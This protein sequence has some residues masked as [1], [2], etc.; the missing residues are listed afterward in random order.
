MCSDSCW[1]NFIYW[2]ADAIF[3]VSCLL[4][5]ELHLLIL[6]GRGHNRWG[7]HYHVWKHTHISLFI[8]VSDNKLISGHKNSNWVNCPTNDGGALPY[9]I[10]AGC[11]MREGVG[12]TWHPRPEHL[13]T[14]SCI[15]LNPRAGG[16][17]LAGGQ[18]PEPSLTT[19]SHWRPGGGEQWRLCEIANSGELSPSVSIT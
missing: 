12:E 18:M 8:S 14:A 13:F 2:L 11:E 19:C 15:L 16:T 4:W 17:W 10:T 6:L 7:D 5:I 1:Y 3:G 9:L